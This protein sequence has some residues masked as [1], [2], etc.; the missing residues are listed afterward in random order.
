MIKKIAWDVFKN[1]GNINTFLEF[2]Q[3]EE[4]EKNIQINSNIK[5]QERTQTKEYDFLDNETKQQNNEGN[6]KWLI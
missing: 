2:K 1:T 4:L 6:E 5:N 3:I